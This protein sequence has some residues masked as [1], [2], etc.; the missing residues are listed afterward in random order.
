MNPILT[1][2]LCRTNC[3]EHAGHAF[4]GSHLIIEENPL[5]EAS[6]VGS[7]VRWHVD[8]HDK[9]LPGRIK[10]VFGNITRHMRQRPSFSGFPIPSPDLPRFFTLHSRAV[11]DEATIL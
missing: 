1:P 5:F 2:L 7:E 10:G 9:V 11:E 4:P 3:L 8:L 6:F